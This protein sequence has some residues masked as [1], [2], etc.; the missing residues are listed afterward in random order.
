MK[1]TVGNVI[2]LIVLGCILFWIAA[3]IIGYY[4]LVAIS[5]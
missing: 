2:Q 1:I 5:E 3:G 4:A